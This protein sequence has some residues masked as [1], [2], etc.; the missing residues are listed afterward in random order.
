[1][2]LWRYFNP[3]HAMRLQN[4]VGTLMNIADNPTQ[5]SGGGAWREQDTLR[6]IPI[7]LTGQQRLNVRHKF[8]CKLL[9]GGSNHLSEEAAEPAARQAPSNDSPDFMRLTYHRQRLSTLR[10]CRQSAAAAWS[11]RRDLAESA[12]MQYD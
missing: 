11:S 3:T 2:T 5:V 8:I 6:R 7:I 4:A 12:G 10:L 9:E 1:M